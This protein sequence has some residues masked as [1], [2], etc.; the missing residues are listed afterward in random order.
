MKKYYIVFGSKDSSLFWDKEQ[1]T[2]EFHSGCC[3]T[4]NLYLSTSQESMQ[5]GAP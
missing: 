4:G 1:W 2:L 5:G 3:F